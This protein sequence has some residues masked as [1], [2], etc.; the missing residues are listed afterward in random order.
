MFSQI[1]DRNILNRIF[2]LL[3]GSCVRGGTFGAG[4][5]KTLVW[6]FAMAPHR[7]RVRVIFFFTCEESVRTRLI[8]EELVR[9]FSDVKKLV[10]NVHKCEE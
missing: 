5:S 10:L 8:F 6:G 9:F 2:I 1:K 7:L 3:P 4:G